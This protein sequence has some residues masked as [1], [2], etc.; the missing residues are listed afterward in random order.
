[1]FESRL[2]VSV[3]LPG[4]SGL[5]PYALP[6]ASGRPRADPAAAF[7]ALFE[8]PVAAVPALFECL[9]VGVAVPAWR[10]PGHAVYH[11]RPDAL[12][13]TLRP[14]AGSDLFGHLNLLHA[15]RV[16]FERPVASVAALLASSLVAVF[17]AAFDPAAVFAALF[18]GPPRCA[19]LHG[20]GLLRGAAVPRGAAP[21][22]LG[23]LPEF[24]LVLVCVGSLPGA[25]GPRPCALPGA[26]GQ[27][28]AVLLVV[29]AALF[30]CLAVA[31]LAASRSPPFASAALFAYLPE[32]AVYLALPGALFL[33]LRLAVYLGLACLLYPLRGAV[34]LSGRLVENAAALFVRLPADAFAGRSDLSVVFAAA[35]GGPL[36]G[37]RLHGH[38]LLRGAV[39]PRGAALALLG[40][41]QAFQLV[42][43]DAVSLPGAS[44]L[45][46]Y[47]LPGAFGQLVADPAAAFAGFSAALL[48]ASLPLCFCPLVLSAAFA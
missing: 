11:V 42:L 38:G 32:R 2:D 47:A 39:G 30:E 37:A 40:V 7:L 5:R 19:R 22:L 28:Y 15:F 10:L 36:R 3:S 1:M 31:A 14:A 45:R 27:F 6:G 44:G 43:D 8:L 29:F 21:V 17:A 46:P 48:F 34:V 4:A 35:S 9:P 12:V 13:L 18:G 26:S 16:L 41:L 20:R 23:V 33:T 25:S 24:Q